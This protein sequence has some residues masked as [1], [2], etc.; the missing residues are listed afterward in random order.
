[1][2]I[3][4]FQHMAAEGPGLVAEW[5]TQRGHTL[6][7]TQWYDPSPTLPNLAEADLLVV[8]GG[9][10]GVHDEAEFPWL[11]AEKQLLQAA[12]AAGT[13]V[14]GICLG[15]Q[16]LAQL[17]GADVG[18]NAAPEVGF[19]PVNFS[20][21]AR[22]HPLFQHAPAALPVLHWHYDAFTLPPGAM[23]VAASAATS[24]QAYVFD[25]RVVG[26]QFHP[27]AG[28][29]LLNALI[30]AEGADLTA[31]P[32]VQLPPELRAQATVLRQGPDF[33]FPLLDG[34]LRRP[35]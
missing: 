30:E 23:A 33:L 19:F 10:M 12:L 24:C 32:Y 3:H 5:A 8:L 25:D 21:A 29:E 18:R 6:S 22:Q 14:L 34:L 26:V 15:S 7:S 17:L 28:P 35:V 20:A 31:G 9:A 2:R 1:M 11:Q 27:E 4:Y 16:L 13:P